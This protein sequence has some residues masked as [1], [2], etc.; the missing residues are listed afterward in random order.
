MEVYADR[1]LEAKLREFERKNQKSVEEAIK[2]HAE[3]VQRYPFREQPEKIEELTSEKIYNPRTQDYFLGWIEFK[4]KGLGRIFTGSALY[5]EAARESP[6]E[7][8]KLL[9]VAVDACRTIAEK[10]DAS[11]ES[12]RGFGGDKLVAKKI[13]FCYFP[14]TMLP[15]FK[16]EHLEHFVRQIGL[17]YARRALSLYGKNYNMLSLGQKCELLNRMLLDAFGYQDRELS[18]YETVLLSKFLYETF[19]PQKLPV[20]VKRRAEPLHRLG[21]LFEPECEQ[22]VVY[23]FAVLHRDMGF[24]Y[25]LKIRGEF[26]DAVVIDRNKETK[27]IEF[28]FRA[29]DFLQHGHPKDGCNYIVCRENDLEEPVE[30]MPEILELKEFVTR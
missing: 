22:E 11:W 8:R 3:F 24:P 7:F 2:I 19:P 21:I 20:S 14:E 4:L 16:T 6:E 29:S 27:T 30:G 15:I 12:I 5:A 25:V 18:I 9:K 26:P 10:I 13:I 1:E 28:E 17:D 23:L